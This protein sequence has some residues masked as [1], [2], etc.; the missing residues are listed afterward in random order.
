MNMQAECLVCLYNQA[1]RVAKIAATDEKTLSKVM[2]FSAYEIGS[3]ELEQTP[4]NA[5]ARLYPMISDITKKEDPYKEKKKLSTK[6]ALQYKAFVQDMIKNS[7]DKLESAI[8]A[9]IAGNVIDFATEV[10]FDFE[11][12]IK[13]IYQM[14]FAI[15][16][17]DILEKKLKNAKNIVIIGDNAGEHVFDKIMIE[18]IKELFPEIMI[19]YFTRGAP[20]IND[21]T[22]KDAIDIKMN[23]VCEVV[24]SGMK[25]PGFLPLRGTKEALEL[26]NSADLI[27][28]KGMG[29][30][31]CMEGLKNEKLFFLFKVKCQVVANKIGKNIGDIICKQ[32]I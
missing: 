6:M 16:D 13:K 10:S 20:I 27:I 29:N 12:E 30:F 22:L 2:Q 7:T 5:A 1:L 3:F 9:S 25:L 28:A 4:P 21:I 19:Y 32:N 8:R 15:C 24:D 18:T 31:E 11:Q 23:E 14:D 26:Y 17:K